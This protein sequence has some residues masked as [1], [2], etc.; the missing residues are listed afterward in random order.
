LDPVKIVNAMRASLSG[1]GG[2]YP[3]IPK[4]GG[5]LLSK[6]W[7]HARR[8]FHALVGVAF[9]FFAG[10]GATLAFSEWRAYSAT[11]SNGV[12]RFGLLAGFTLLLLMFGLYSFLKARN[13]R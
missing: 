13:V 12:W 9:L 6:G 7:R 3:K 11:P 4:G 8:I 2:P 10:A 5:Q 1:A